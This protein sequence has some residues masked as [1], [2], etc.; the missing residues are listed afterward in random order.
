MTGRRSS[1]NVPVAVTSFVG[2]R[3]EIVEVR[4]LLAGARLV[5]LTG[6]GGVGKTR[7]ALE[8][9]HQSARGFPDGVWLVE[10]A[11]VED[12]AQVAQ[13]VANALGIL[14]QSNRP[15]LDKI[16][17]QLRDRRAL[18][19]LDNCEHL[20]DACAAFADCVLRA[21]PGVRVLAT[22][23]RALEIDGE[24]LL[25]VPP[26][27]V[28]GSDLEAGALGQYEAVG[29]LVERAA[30]I[31][32][33]FAVNEHNHRAIAGLCAQLDGIPLA[34]ELAASRLRSLSAADLLDRLE[35]RFAVLTGGSRAALPRQQTLRALIDW[36]YGLCSE[37][38]RLL[39][40]RLS[41]FS[42]GFDLHAAEGICAGND[43]ES[44]ADLLDR[45]VSQS[46]VVAEY[47]DGP[48]RFRLLETIRQYGRQRLAG[49]GQE[50]VLQ[51]RHRDFYMAR[52]RLV[53]DEWG[54]P[55]QEEGLA[56]LRADH[57]NLRAALELCM[58]DARS[59]LELTA[60]LRHH[61]YADG[62]LSEGRGWLDRALSLPN[63]PSDARASTLWVAAWVCLLQGDY[64]LARQRLA[65]CER[66]GDPVS[67]AFAA[68]LEGTAAMFSGDDLDLVVRLT[69][70]A[71]VVLEDNPEGLPVAMFQLAI[72]LAL[73]GNTERA[74]LICECALTFC[75]EHGERWIRTY[76]LWVLSYA[77]WLG[78]SAV[79]ATRQ[80]HEALTI[81]RG[82]NDQV[83][84]ALIIELMAWIAGSQANSPKAAQLLGVANSL[85]RSIGTTIDAFGPHH[86]ANHARCANA[87]RVPDLGNLTV[88][89]AIALA[90]DERAAPVAAED[91]V[92]TRR[93]LEVAELV[94]RGLSNRAIAE[95]LVIS[96]RTVDGHVEHIL[97]KLA[98]TGRSQIAAW[99]TER[100]LRT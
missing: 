75:A 58:A 100:S 54:G 22:S 86:A 21:A 77:T 56:L 13:L 67:R 9:A 48:V 45:L 40:A 3:R 15:P 84:A 83:G 28:P 96:T 55:G 32:P 38:E 61:W 7:L 8:V 79:E 65:E 53:A 37:A 12:G 85:W 93:E 4:R 39:W 64:D 43:L 19:V 30:A 68:I 63:Q 87:V 81:Q 42:G 72:S 46:I 80:A 20:L 52:A 97:T 91:P 33:G 49:S 25:T 36:S 57:S 23:R 90:L 47:G 82:F 6:V 76:V 18:I 59:A 71:I 5:T 27:S 41:V 1:G 73:S 16:T 70:K 95:S 98:F 10:L 17:D 78:G 34:I 26:L 51:R 2:R 60:S 66:L 89:E 88:A 24:Y 35:D 50:G 74:T 31:Q 69:E 44:V 11:G 94:T 14:D 62:F 29:L 92:L 99:M